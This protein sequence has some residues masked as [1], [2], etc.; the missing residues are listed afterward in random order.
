MGGFLSFRASVHCA[1]NGENA[2]RST[3]ITYRIA[4]TRC[5]MTIEV[6]NI[7]TNKMIQLVL[8]FRECSLFIVYPP[9]AFLSRGAKKFRSV[10]GGAEKNP[11]DI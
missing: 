5:S 3:V 10:L 8:S 6:M 7:P 4:G 9:L 2:T 11:V 1:E